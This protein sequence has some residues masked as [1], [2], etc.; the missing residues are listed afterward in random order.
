MKKCVDSMAGCCY[1]CSAKT[2]GVCAN[3]QNTHTAGGQIRLPPIRFTRADGATGSRSVAVEER[4][5]D[6]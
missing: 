6:E 3:A 1:N 2:K 4:L 5:E